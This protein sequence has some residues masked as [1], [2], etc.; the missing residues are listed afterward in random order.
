VEELYIVAEGL[1]EHVLEVCAI[2]LQEV[3]CDIYVC[4]VGAILSVIYK[5]ITELILVTELEIVRLGIIV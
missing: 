4:I 2:G 5:G 1:E 3:L